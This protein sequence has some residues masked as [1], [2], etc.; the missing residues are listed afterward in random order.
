MADGEVYLDVAGT[1]GKGVGKTAGD[2][3]AG[4]ARLIPFEVVL[5]ARL[6]ARE[7]DGLG[8]ARAAARLGP[9]VQRIRGDYRERHGTAGSGWR[10]GTD[11]DPV[12]G[13]LRASATQ[14]DKSPSA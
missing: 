14:W 9:A 5:R 1:G 11:G 6:A 13:N 7:G 8:R 4:K 12:S 10:D 3:G 2:D